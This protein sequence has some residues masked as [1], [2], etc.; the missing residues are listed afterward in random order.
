[1]IV[2][3][4]MNSAIYCREE[5][6]GEMVACDN[7]DCSAGKWFQLACLKLK[8]KPLKRQWYC[9]NCRKLPEFTTKRLHKNES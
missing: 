8:Q 7:S 5:T 9:P 4:L 6:G 2:T 1:M 3:H